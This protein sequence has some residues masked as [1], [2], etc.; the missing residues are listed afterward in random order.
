MNEKYEYMSYIMKLLKG[1]KVKYEKKWDDWVIMPYQYR[2]LYFYA[3]NNRYKEMKMSIMNGIPITPSL[4]TDPISIMINKNYQRCLKLFFDSTQTLLAKNPYSLSFLD[5]DILVKINLQ[6]NA[7]LNK[8]Y[9]SIFVKIE[10]EDFPKFAED[11]ELP[12]FV[13]SDTLTPAISNFFQV[14]ESSLISEIDTNMTT[15]N[16]NAM[17]DKTINSSFQD[18]GNDENEIQVKTVPIVLY[19]SSIRLNLEN[20]TYDS[21]NFINSLLRCPNTE[22][23]RTKFIQSLLRS[24]WNDLKKWQW[25]QAICYGI[26]IAM[27]SVYLVFLYDEDIGVLALLSFGILLSLYD[28]FQMYKNIRLFFKD[29]WNYFDLLRLILLV[30]YIFYYFYDHEDSKYVIIL[31]AII[32]YIRGISFFR[33]FDDTRYMIQLLSNIIKGMKSFTI[34]LAYS[35]FSFSFIFM[36]QAEATGFN[37]FV[38]YFRNTFLMNIGGSNFGQDSTLYWAIFG[39]AVIVNVIVMMNMLIAIMS[40]TFNKV[41]LDTELAD[42]IEIAEM[43]LEV[44]LLFMK[45]GKKNLTYFQLCEA[46]TVLGIGDEQARDFKSMKKM[47]KLL[48]EKN[49][50]SIS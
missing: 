26:F 19:A 13:F 35:S 12:K 46:E 49:Q 45:Q 36:I 31:M 47:L 29:I 34:L 7:K 48:C 6:G 39:C 18:M 28:V 2:T 25:I 14:K 43:V 16:P 40:E 8:F 33:L 27:L 3:Y 17:K 9:D 21:I 10:T 42:Y 38:W 23:F 4:T 11:S 22:I 30:A 32:C 50:I 37:S 20:G 24:K 5:Q 44:E 15:L 41:R 1:E